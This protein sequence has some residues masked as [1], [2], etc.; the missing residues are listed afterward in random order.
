MRRVAGVI[1]RW[2]DIE[3]GG[4]VEGGHHALRSGAWCAEARTEVFLGIGRSGRSG[5]DGDGR[6]FE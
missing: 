6:L 2:S 3:R 5:H 1:L 4:G